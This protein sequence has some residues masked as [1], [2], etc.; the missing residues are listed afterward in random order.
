MVKWVT[1]SAITVTII[2]VNSISFIKGASP[3]FLISVFKEHKMF[4][5][6][7]K[8]YEQLLA[9]IAV[10]NGISRNDAIALFNVVRNHLG[11]VK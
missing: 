4:Y 10:K 1:L 2:S 9:H 8:D 11:T 6:V 3:P 5:P 7:I